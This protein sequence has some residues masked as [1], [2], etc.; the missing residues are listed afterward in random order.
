MAQTN[1]QDSLRGHK[2]SVV[3]LEIATHNGIKILL[4][5]S[6]D[7]TVRAWN[8]QVRPKLVVETVARS[9]ACLIFLS[10]PLFFLLDLTLITKIAFRMP[11]VYTLFMDTKMQFFACT[12]AETWCFQAARM[13]LFASGPSTCVFFFA[14]PCIFA[15]NR[16][17]K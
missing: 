13:A 7:K 8:I 16:Y 6:K 12:R 11:R 10:C 1:K 2:R 5:G 4:S 3:C 17:F 9:L 15:S 14:I